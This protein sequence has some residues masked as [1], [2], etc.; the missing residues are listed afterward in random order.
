MPKKIMLTD[1]Q[2]SWLRAN[3]RKTSITKIAKR[4]GVCTDTAKRIMVRYDLAQFPGAKY[5]KPI[6][7]SVANWNRPCL[8]CGCTKTRPRQ[9]YYCRPCRNR[10]G[11][12]NYE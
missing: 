1:E 5:V 11:Y 10:R 2:L 7:T 6:S 8:D 3:Y 12:S 4:L 9:W